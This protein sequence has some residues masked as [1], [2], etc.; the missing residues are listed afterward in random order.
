MTPLEAA[1][2]SAREAPAAAFFAWSASPPSTASR[3]LRTAVFSADLTD[4][5]RSCAA[6]FCLLRLIWD[7]MFTRG[8]ASFCWI[9]G[10]GR[11]HEGARAGPDTKINDISG[12]LR[13]PNRALLPAPSVAEPAPERLGVPDAVRAEVRRV[14]G[15]RARRAGHHEATQRGQPHVH[16]LRG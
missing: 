13:R 12:P 11:S 16:V 1:L 7:L 2:S 9:L 10:G 14:E 5:L 15:R 4:L 8:Q 6:S 3:N